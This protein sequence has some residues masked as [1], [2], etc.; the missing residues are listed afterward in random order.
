[1]GASTASGLNGLQTALQA[2]LADEVEIGKL[3]ANYRRYGLGHST[4]VPAETQLRMLSS[5]ADLYRQ[6]ISGSGTGPVARFGRQIAAWDTSPTHAVALR[7]G[8]LGVSRQSRAECSMISSPMS[9][10]VRCAD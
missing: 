2:E 9:S 5:A 3:Y 1:M 10:A 7:I 6:L 4:P 8:A